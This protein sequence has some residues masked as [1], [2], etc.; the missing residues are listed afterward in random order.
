MAM[1]RKHLTISRK[2]A[3][4]RINEIFK[5]S[6]RVL[7]DPSQWPMF[8]VQT[9]LVD[10]VYADF[11]KLHVELLTLCEEEEFDIEDDVRKSVDDQ[12]HTIKCRYDTLVAT[13]TDIPTSSP[14]NDAVRLPKLELLK[15]SGEL[16]DWQAYID[17]FDTSVHNRTDISEIHKFQYLLSTLLGEPLTL[18]QAISLSSANYMTAYET[19]VNRFSNKRLITLTHWR[20]LKNF[21]AL[22]NADSKKLRLL[23]DTFSKNLSVLRN[24][25]F[26]VD[27]WDFPITDMI[28]DKLDT[29]TRERFE[30]TLDT[31]AIPTYE[32]VHQFLTKQCVALETVNSSKTVTKPHEYTPK[33]DF[34][35]RKIMSHVVK[36]STEPER[37]IICNGSH[38]IFMCDKFKKKSV[39]ERIDIIKNSGRC[40][41]CFR[42]NHRSNQCPTSQ[43]CREC[44][45]RHHTLLHVP[46]VQKPFE[47]PPQDEPPLQTAC[48]SNGVISCNSTV[49]HSTSTTLLATTLL[50]IRDKN[51]TDHVLRAVIDSGSQASFII[52][53]CVNRLQLP[54]SPYRSPVFG[55]GNVSSNVSLGVVRC[56][57]KACSATRPSIL[58]DAIVLPH[59]CSN[60]PSMTLKRSIWKMGTDF[61]LADPKW[62]QPGG[63][64]MLI[65]ADIY[66]SI[67][68]S[69]ILPAVES[70]PMALQ[71]IFGWTLIGPVQTNE[72][73]AIQSFF[74]SIDQPID[75][76]NKFVEL[77]EVPARK[78]VHPDDEQAE[79]P[80][81]KP[82]VRHPS[83][84]FGV[85]L[86][87]KAANRIFPP[88]KDVV[89]RRSPS[90]EKLLANEKPLRI[91]YQELMADYVTPS[92]INE[93]THIPSDPN[94]YFIPPHAVVNL[95]NGKPN[96]RVVLAS[97]AKTEHQ[98][99][100]R[101]SDTIGKLQND[102]D[103]LRTLGL[104][105]EI[106]HW[107]A[108]LLQV[109]PFNVTCTKRFNLS[110]TACVANP[111][112]LICPLSLYVKV[113]IREDHKVILVKFVEAKSKVAPVKS[114]SIPRLELCVAILL[115]SLV[116]FVIYSFQNVMINPFVSNRVAHIQERVP[117]DRLRCVP[118]SHNP[119][120]LPFL[121]F[122]PNDLLRASL[123]WAAFS[124]LGHLPM[125]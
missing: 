54:I 33:P 72:P 101:I 62:Y 114:L 113:L 2:L 70:Q 108:N 60:L 110:Q 28:L 85:N 99:S 34:R 86:P 46:V 104:G 66:P 30:L 19:L 1:T 3:A 47:T 116:K 73:T 49:P 68:L 109:N 117:P 103:I 32:E 112:G 8:K 6:E 88:S 61:P 106:L 26:D 37:C 100:I 14:A 58:A 21:P 51:G 120:D 63:I 9:S 94:G 75:T 98:S 59:I 102:D 69:G 16:C 39:P 111:L 71:T 77:E 92:H 55:L 38:K 115:S 45:K 91:L 5:V 89:K 121:V 35:S 78:L 84:R 74:A 123:W 56:E 31:S 24:L 40:Y 122:L 82:L 50:T 41:N 125:A 20:E 36:T 18:I 29:K 81:Q 11:C 97:S 17:V 118:S 15:F 48:S 42:T 67:V 13:P 95:E 96:L 22:T 80:F 12:Y 124:W 93:V 105:L 87:F 25:E 57:I 7:S 4:S 119:A 23:V 90:L 79:T 83:G 65:G 76:I 53:N 52:R 44:H 107:S 10:G 64:D 43:K 27:A